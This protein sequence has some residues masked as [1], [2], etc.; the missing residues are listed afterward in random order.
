MVLPIARALP[1]CLAGREEQEARCSGGRLG[2]THEAPGFSSRARET[3]DVWCVR[4]V[5]KGPERSQNNLEGVSSSDNSLLVYF[6]KKTVTC[7]VWRCRCGP[8]INQ[9]SPEAPLDNKLVSLRSL[10]R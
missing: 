1:R 3:R 10:R 2:L 9:S 8:G 5:Q 4:E 6:R 7:S